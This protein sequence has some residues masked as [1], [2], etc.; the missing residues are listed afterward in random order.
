MLNKINNQAILAFDKLAKENYTIYSLS[1][2]GLS[3]TVTN[4]NISTNESLKIALKF[5]DFIRFKAEY[6]NNFFYSNYLNDGTYLPYF[7]YNNEKVIIQILVPTNDET[8][9]KVN[10]KKLYTMLTNEPVRFDY[11]IKD[12]SISIGYVVDSIYNKKPEFWILL[13]DVVNNYL[14]EIDYINF[15]RYETIEIEGHKYP[16]LDEIIKAYNKKT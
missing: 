14:K 1:G 2:Q 16:Y 3:D 10:K 6:P 12:K 11:F 7:K 13:D 8:Y 5:N 9:K 15:D 4:K